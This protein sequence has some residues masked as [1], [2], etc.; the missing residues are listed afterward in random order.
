M[1]AESLNIREHID[2]L[3]HRLKIA[4][5]SYVALLAVLMLAPAEPAKALTFTGTYVPF[6]AFF[7]A[8]VKLDLLPAG[9]TLIANN[10]SEPLEVYLIASIILAAV[11]NS[12]IFAYETIRFISPALTEKERGLLY[13]FVVTASALFTVGILFGYF[14]LAK[15]LFIALAPFFETAQAQPFVDVSN[16]YSVVFLVIGMSGIAFTSPIYVYMLIR[17]R[18]L[19]PATFRRNRVIIWVVVY[20]ITAIITPDGGPVLDIILFVPIIVMLEL[21]VWLGARSAGGLEPGPAPGACR[22]C[23]ARLG[24]ASF[25]P[26]CGRAAS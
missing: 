5:L 9:W 17:F 7:L 6:V 14:L 25:C 15:F 11:F 1:S 2:E 13:P 22:Y 18:V 4:F 24:G 8:R 10:L 21:A 12:P 23:G 20:I 3:K 16:F 26:S 19:S